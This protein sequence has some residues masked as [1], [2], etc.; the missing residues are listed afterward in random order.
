MASEN[1]TRTGAP[2]TPAN[3]SDEYHGGFTCANRT[4]HLTSE[5]PPEHVE[6]M[7]AA[8]RE[9]GLPDTLD[10]IRAAIA[11]LPDEDWR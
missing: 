5:A 2:T 4:V 10:G 7:M 1:Q 9:M 8:M 11:A 6:L 3:Q